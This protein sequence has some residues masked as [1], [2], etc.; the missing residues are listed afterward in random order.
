MDEAT[1]QILH[2]KEN[3]VSIFHFLFR[4]SLPLDLKFSSSLFLF[5]FFHGAFHALVLADE[6]SHF[7]LLFLAPFPFFFFF[8][9]SSFVGERLFLQE[10]C[11]CGGSLDG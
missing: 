11:F 10:L 6:V 5:L 3:M 7:S 2:Y 9:D 8:D 1:Y 4:R